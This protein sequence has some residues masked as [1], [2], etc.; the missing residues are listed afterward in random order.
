MAMIRAL[1]TALLCCVAVFVGD[2]LFRGSVLSHVRPVILSPARQAVLQ[3]PVV[4]QWDGPQPMRVSISIV[5]EAPREL[6]DLRSPVTLEANDFP[7][8]GG[9]QIDLQSPKFGRWIRASRR[10]QVHALPSA[11]PSEPS[12]QA[13]NDHQGEQAWDVHDLLRAL[14]AARTARDKAHARSKFLTEE[15]SA[16]RDESERLAK[17]LES[18]Y[19][20]Q[21][22]D[23]HHGADLERRLN[24]LTDENHAL[25]DQ[26]AAMRLRLSTVI[27]CT[28]WG[29]FGIPHP[30]TYP[31]TRRMLVV[32][33]SRGE[34]FRAQPQCELL[35]RGDPNAASICFCIGNSWGG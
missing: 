12:P 4:L 24:Q 6:G 14:E 5:G 13:D 25:A 34:V 22:E 20:S 19:N 16:L 18:I 8:E 30:N 28:V 15:N 33:D 23:V 26:N 10:F 3:P 35:R 32:S 1:F 7:R 9:Y 2:L 17:Q 21:E 11:R 31:P 29:Y 27:P